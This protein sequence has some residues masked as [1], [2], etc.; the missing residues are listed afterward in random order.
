MV[1]SFDVKYFNNHP[2]LCSVILPDLHK[3]GGKEGE[4]EGRKKGRKERKCVH[5]LCV[6]EFIAQ[7]H[8]CKDY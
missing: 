5:R 4:R 8:T 3:K 6:K 2:Y 7:I 1:V